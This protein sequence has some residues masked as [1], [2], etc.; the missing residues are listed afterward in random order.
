MYRGQYFMKYLVRYLALWRY[1]L[2]IELMR[3]V[4]AFEF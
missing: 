1:A 4:E 2:Y 3:R